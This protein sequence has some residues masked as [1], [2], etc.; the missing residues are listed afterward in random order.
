MAEW[1]LTHQLGQFLD[2]HLVLPL[3][4]FLST[5]IVSWRIIEWLILLSVLIDLLPSSPRYMM[6][7]S[8]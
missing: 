3:L 6:E 5:N 1:E 7:M 8:C 2:R 4:E